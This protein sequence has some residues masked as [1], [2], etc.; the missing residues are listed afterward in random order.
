MYK[1]AINRPIATFMLFF[2]LVIFGLNSY[3][4]MPLNL[5]PNVEIPLIKITA[6]ANG[7]KE[8][9]ESKI[10]K[11]IEDEVGG[12]SGIDKIFSSSFD[13][14]G[15]VL[16]QF[17]LNKSLDEAA[18]D[19]RDKLAKTEF[20]NA[21]EIEKLSGDSGKIYSLFLQNLGSDKAK[22]MQKID[23]EILPFIK[24]IEGVG[25]TDEIGFLKPE[26]RVFLDR[27]KLQKFHLNAA[28]IIQIIK[29]SNFKFPVG[30]LENSTSEILIKSDLEAK[31]L[32]ELKNIKI[33]PN[34]Q[35]K[36]IATIEFGVSDLDSLAIFNSQNGVIIDIS[37]VIGANSVKTIKNIEKNLDELS[38]I[39][40]ENIKITPIFSKFELIDRNLSQVLHDLI[41]GL[42]L[43][44]FIVYFFLRNAVFTLISAISIP[45]SI[46]GTFFI[47]DILGYDLNRLTLIALTLGIGI[48]IDDAIV[49]IENISKKMCSQTPLIAS[50]NG[51]K[52]ISFSVLAI[53]VILLCVFV[54]MGF[55]NS[56][57]GRFFNSFALSIASGVVVSFFVSIMLIP[58]LCARFIRTSE[59][60]EPQIFIKMEN[61]YE[62]ILRVIILRKKAFTIGVLAIM[63][64]FMALALR[65]GADFMVMEDNAEFELF[66]EADSK[67]SLNSMQE[68]SAEILNLIK[69]DE[70][71]EY[72][73][74]MIGYTDAKEANKA[75][76]YVKLKNVNERK[77]RQG[78]IIESWR[79]KFAKFS[80]F[81]V[82][83]SAIPVVES[84]GINEPIQLVIM[85]ENLE[86]LGEIS[87]KTAEILSKIKGV[88]DIKSTFDDKK[89]SLKITLNREI[90]KKVGLSEQNFAQILN[91]TF[92]SNVVGSFDTQK[93][94][95]DIVVRIKD[96]NRQNIDD[97]RSLSF[98]NSQGEE[99]LF[100]SV[101]KIEPEISPNELKRFNRQKEILITANIAEISLDS[102]INSLKS[103]LENLPNG[104]SYKFIGQ[105]ELMGQTYEAFAFT[106]ILSAVLIY[107]VLASLYESLVL[108][109]IVLLTMP[110]AFSGVSL[111]LFLSGNSFSLFVM[112]GVIL[113]FGMVGKNAI[114]VVDFANRLA[115]SGISIDEAVIKAGKL[116]L[117]AI[118][119]TTFAMIFAMLPL[120]FSRGA[121]YEG[122][123]PMAIAIISGLISS[124]I[125]TLLLIPAIFDIL[126]KFDLFLRKFYEREKIE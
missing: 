65:L 19:I 32:D 60:K 124:T 120:A 89:E 61:F 58:S 68:K 121:G 21:V 104:Y 53:S 71:V 55:M 30:K 56:I 17:K 86:K 91:A 57:V 43:T 13:Y 12:V 49:V 5:F 27:F 50:F 62:K 69:S 112:V 44:L 93:A 83:I 113:L 40:G 36:D 4:T 20:S 99:I 87:T 101:A 85:G 114:L 115:K 105:A 81:K 82:I 35:L 79:E 51:V 106:I 107:M 54:P 78:K 122:N 63:S 125:L 3:F 46:I 64:L 109:F 24:R 70:N 8:Y 33:T 74:E 96:A 47:M 37:K 9:I 66:L 118:L 38:K 31:N 97:L 34:L 90:A 73:Y 18:N 45:V 95:Y 7:D 11:V 25:N 41:L 123:S 126:Y 39:S 111:G 2:A 75:K 72:A 77:F 116:R 10:L 14:V 94:K 52:E 84:A 67:I 26:I 108:P 15:V 42:I 1:F 117:K 59:N 48:F 16:V 80:D 28:E 76:I 29:N 110:L 6:K 92:S 102:V 98:K 119:M 88:R 22:F 103:H 23:T 100:D